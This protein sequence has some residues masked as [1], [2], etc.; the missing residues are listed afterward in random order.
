MNFIFRQFGSYNKL[1][2]EENDFLDASE[3]ESVFFSH[4]TSSPMSA[5][6]TNTLHAPSVNTKQQNISK[7]DDF[8]YTPSENGD[9]IDFSEHNGIKKD[10]SMPESF[11]FYQSLDELQ[12]AIKKTMKT[13]MSIDKSNEMVSS[14]F[15][16]NASNSFGK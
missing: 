2:V 14:P 11:E 6:I 5:K 9:L 13:S 15:A 10:E 16:E 4:A 7:Q 12:F 1:R 3:E 8:D